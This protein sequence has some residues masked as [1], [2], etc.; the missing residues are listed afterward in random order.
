MHNKL[1]TEQQCIVVPPFS[2]HSLGRARKSLFT[3]KQFSKPKHIA[4]KIKP[5]VLRDSEAVRRGR[6]KEDGGKEIGGFLVFVKRKKGTVS[7][8]LFSDF[9][10]NK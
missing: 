4:K 5:F 6:R 10:L 1:H 9:L 2:S 8:Y 7:I 3:H